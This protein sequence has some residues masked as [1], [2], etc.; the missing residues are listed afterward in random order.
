M[1]DALEDSTLCVG[2]KLCALR[3]VILT[4]ERN[5]LRNREQLGEIPIG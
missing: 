1:Y 2:G 4:N 3:L 5:G